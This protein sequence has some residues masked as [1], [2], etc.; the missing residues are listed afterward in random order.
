[1][2][3]NILVHEQ[4]NEHAHEHYVQLYMYMK[5]NM[6]MYTNIMYMHMNVYTSMYMNMYTYIYMKVFTD[7]Y[8][9][10][11]WIRS[12]TSAFTCFGRC[13]SHTYMWTVTNVQILY[14]N[15]SKNMTCTWACSRT[16]IN[17][18]S[19]IHE[20]FQEH[21]HVHKHVL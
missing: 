19:Q 20:Y 18:F 5:M 2:C 17:L 11:T 13:T 14:M 12:Q 8:S 16:N 9:K 10:W 4:I 7:K 1:M 3:K 21:V 6:H 15:M